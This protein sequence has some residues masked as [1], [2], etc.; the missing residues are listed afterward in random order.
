MKKHLIFSLIAG[1]HS[2]NYSQKNGLCDKCGKMHFPHEFNEGCC[3]ICGMECNHDNAMEEYNES[4]H[5]CSICEMTEAHDLILDDSSNY[6]MK[7][8][9][10]GHTIQHTCP[11][12]TES[13][14][15]TCSVCGETF[16]SHA[17]L[18]GS[19]CQWCGYECK[20]P[21]L[22]RTSYYC[23]SCK[24][25]IYKGNATWLV[26]GKNTYAGSYVHTSSEP[27]LTF[28]QRYTYQSGKWYNDDI[29][30]CKINI[31]EPTQYGG[32]YAYTGTGFVFTRSITNFPVNDTLLSGDGKYKVSLKQYELDGT[33]R[34][35]SSYT[36]ADCANIKIS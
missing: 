19:E 36:S 5:K 27:G 14:C 22:D 35:E 30:L 16:S 3:S 23:E 6:C 31:N 17:F 13:S 10:C 1:R 7:C 9:V 34:A 33:F 11:D 26:T 21:T 18:S 4:W 28:Y 15:G 32:K 2:H 29:Y 20:H 12:K 8:S 24:R 25:T